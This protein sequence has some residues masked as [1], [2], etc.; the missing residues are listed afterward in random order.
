MADLRIVT[1]ALA[2]TTLFAA[3]GGQPGADG[4]S[5]AGEMESAPPAEAPAT[6]APVEAAT[7]GGAS[8]ADG[9]FSEAQAERGYMVFRDTC[10]DCHG[11]S[12]MHGADF[13][14]EWEGSSVG[15]LYRMISRT[16]PDDD[17]GSLPRQ[18]YIDVLT[19]ILDLND[20]PAGSADLMADTERLDLLIIGS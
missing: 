6:E 14:F 19:Y 16:M 5:P 15:R 3:C 2:A 7:P 18:N 11:T 20:F 9:V 17:P 8:L 13:M 1:A 12:E 4:V 10:A